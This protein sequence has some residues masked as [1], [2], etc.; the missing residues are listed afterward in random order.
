MSTEDSVKKQTTVVRSF[1]SILVS[2]FWTIVTF[3]AIYL[4][5]KCNK[6]FDLT[7]FLGALCCSPMYIAYQLAVGNCYS[8]SK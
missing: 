8:I 3:Y 2:L 1:V 4:S 6:G 7:G 5:F